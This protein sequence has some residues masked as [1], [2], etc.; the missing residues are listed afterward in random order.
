[1]SHL[2]LRSS[3][4]SSFHSLVTSS[5]FRRTLI[6]TLATLLSLPVL[7][8]FLERFVDKRWGPL[9]GR[10]LTL[11]DGTTRRI[12]VHGDESVLADAGTGTVVMLVGG[13]SMGA[14]TWAP[15]Q[16]ALEER[17][18]RVVSVA[19]DRAGNGWSP[20]VDDV[21][22]Y[23][24]T[25][26]D[27]AMELH[28]IM[29]ALHLVS[30]D[31]C[32]RHV[33]LVGHSMGASIIQALLFSHPQLTL[34]GI[35]LADPTPVDLFPEMEAGQHAMHA[36]MLRHSQPRLTLL[37]LG[38]GRFYDLPHLLLLGRTPSPSP[39]SLIA[40][41]LTPAERMDL[42]YTTSVRSVGL[43][44]VL[45]EYAVLVPTTRSLARS[46]REGRSTATAPFVRVVEG[47]RLSGIQDV[48]GIPEDEY[49]LMRRK[50]FEDWGRDLCRGVFEGVTTDEGATHVG[51]ILRPMLV[52]VVGE[53]CEEVEKGEGWEGVAAVM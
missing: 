17:E 12:V 51:V 42:G 45:N 44:M 20:A 1:M 25:V 46:R 40:P 8:Q 24:R 31:E 19:Y 6:T 22:T 28:A 41:L 36:W 43:R 52:D 5:I 30:G 29:E 4:T 32:I 21:R 49:Y 50:A 23:T 14:T 15:F 7:H 39:S 38:L 11:K 10:F 13:L 3:I 53:C 16:R 9:C 48:F 18:G 35:I 2:V 34:R 26:D 27:M 37:S 47:D 33:V